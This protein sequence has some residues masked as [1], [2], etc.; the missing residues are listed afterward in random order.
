MVGDRIVDI[1][2]HE[3]LREMRAQ[4]VTVG[5]P[6]DGEVRHGLEPSPVTIR[7]PVPSAAWR[8]RRTTSRR[9]SLSA[10]MRRSPIS[11]T[12][13]W[14]LIE[15]AVA[16]LAFGDPVPRAPSVTAQRPHP[17]V[18]VGMVRH[19][20]A[21]VA[22]SAEVLGRVE[23]ER[24]DI[25]ERPV[26]W[27][28]CRRHRLCAVLDYLHAARATTAAITAVSARLPNRWVTTIACVAGASAGS[29]VAAVTSCVTDPRPYT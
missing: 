17:G 2:V 20:G 10:S 28:P 7:T 5:Y 16:A 19:D 13:A 8:Y 3:A 27:P 12:A 18:D 9:R 14:K 15:A 6:G 22:R 21:A 1:G 29:T 26:R 23:S 25:P 4:G 24:G 11:R